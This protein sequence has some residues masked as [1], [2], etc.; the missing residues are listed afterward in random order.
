MSEKKLC[1]ACGMPFDW[2]GI[3]ED[4]V[5]YCC[6]ECAHGLPCTCPQHDHRSPA[7]S[8]SVEDET[9]RV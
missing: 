1:P 9:V 6:A 4:D 5:E 3:N 7:A 8:G 2:P